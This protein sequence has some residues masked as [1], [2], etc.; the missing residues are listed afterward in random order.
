[1]Q[2]RRV[3]EDILEGGYLVIEDATSDPRLENHEAKKAEGIASILVAP[4]M[5]R[6]RA[7]G[8]LSLYTS[9]PRAF[10]AD[11]IG[12]L[13]AVA[14]QGG[15]AIQHARLLERL[16]QSSRLFY[17]FASMLN[18]SLDIRKILHILSANIGEALRM[19]GIAISLWDGETGKLESVAVYGL[20]EEFW[21]KFPKLGD[22]RVKL[23]LAGETVI[24]RPPELEGEPH[25]IKSML[26][27]PLKAGDEVIGLMAL[28]S[29]NSERF[30]EDLTQLA[31]ALAHQGGLAIRNASTYLM[32]EQE[33]KELE[34]EIWSHKSWF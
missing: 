22:P 29:R 20:S 33:K 6:D 32:L 31:G 5:V 27:Q 24:H 34:R 28:C 16:R 18:A 15:M 4:V 1:M 9:Q 11:E 13:T 10:S 3:V 25:E 17:E 23:A 30:T 21:A 26:Y 2:A 8:V 19:A 12:F 14:E 7:I